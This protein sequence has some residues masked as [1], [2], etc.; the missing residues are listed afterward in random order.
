MHA[1]SSLPSTR[2][3]DGSPATGRRVRAPEAGWLGVDATIGAP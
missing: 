3:Q 1:P 2:A